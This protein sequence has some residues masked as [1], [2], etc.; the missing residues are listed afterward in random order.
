MHFRDY[1]KIAVAAASLNLPAMNASKP[2]AAYGHTVC[3]TVDD[4]P[5]KFLD[6]KLRERFDMGGEAY[7][8][9]SRRR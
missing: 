4:M 6:G 2:P 8:F 9:G 5:V 7:A 1:L 3:G